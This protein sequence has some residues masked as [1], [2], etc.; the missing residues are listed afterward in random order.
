M[1]L[2]VLLHKKRL[3]SVATAIPA[4]SATQPKKEAATVAR[5]ATIA[6]AKSGSEKTQNPL[7]VVTTAP[8][9]TQKV[10]VVCC[11]CANFQRDTVGFGQGIGS[12]TVEQADYQ[13]TPLWPNAQRVCS[14]WASSDLSGSKQA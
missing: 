10:K 14:E 1:M 3:E 9:F 7:R 13:P 11:E 6:V 4:I 8:A 12:C 2:S 5:I